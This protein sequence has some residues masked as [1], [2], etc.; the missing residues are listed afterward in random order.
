MFVTTALFRIVGLFGRFGWRLALLIPLSAII[1]APLALFLTPTLGRCL[2]YGV[3]VSPVVA[4]GTRGLLASSAS[5]WPWSG[6]V[7]RCMLPSQTALSGDGRYPFGDW[8]APLVAPATSGCTYR[9]N[10]S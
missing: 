8:R 5:S 3:G 2:A 4:A 7:S 9:R 6:D 10:T 1:A